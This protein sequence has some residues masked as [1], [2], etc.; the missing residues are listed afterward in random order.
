[1]G[2]QEELEKT[3]EAALQEKREEHE[4]V[5]SFDREW[6]KLRESRVLPLLQEA[7]HAFGKK[8]NGGRAGF[9]NGSAVLG[10]NWENREHSLT[11]RPDKKD[12]MVICSSTFQ[13][14][15]EES[16]TL[17]ALD[18][19]AIKNKVEAFGYR[20]ITGKRRE[21]ESVYEKRGLLVL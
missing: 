5:Q 8:L 6:Q 17:D 21:P 2:F 19:Q 1:M 13:D 14:D 12:Q 10:A 16:F 15:P 3:L 7:A 11:F 4:A 18:E 20:I 9:S